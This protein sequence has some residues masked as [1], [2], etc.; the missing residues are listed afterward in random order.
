MFPLYDN[1][2]T[3]RTPLVT[4][5]LI[6][7]NLLVFLWMSRLP[8]LPQQLMVYQHGF[9]PA[10]VVQLSQPHPILVPIDVVAV[11]PW[12]QRHVEHKAIELAPV[13]GQIWLSLLTCMFLHGSWTHL[14]GNMWFLWLFGNNVEDRLGAFWYVALYL[15][16]GLIGSGAHWAVDPNSTTPV[17][18]ASGAI[19]TVLGAYAITWPWAR[20][21][22]LVFL[23]IFITIVDIPALVVLG[24]W[25]VIQVLES[26]RH[27]A[28]ANVAWWAHI[29]GFLAGMVLM[30]LLSAVVGSVPSKSPTSLEQE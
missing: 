22:C 19:A 24:A 10:R 13:S 16:G 20:V 1:N 4:Y 9:V 12:G 18:G 29:G 3:N 17:I 30:P 27:V 15:V 6:A 2:P 21:S 28:T 14:L 5:A 23:F 26:G 8:E 25:F 11:N 7:V